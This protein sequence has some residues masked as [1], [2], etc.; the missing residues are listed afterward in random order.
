[1]ARQR[2]RQEQQTETEAGQIVSDMTGVSFIRGLMRVHGVTQHIIRSIRR[3]SSNG[4]TRY[5]AIEWAHPT[6][7]IRRVSCN[8]P[9][10][11]NRRTCKHTKEL[12]EAPGLGL[13]DDATLLPDELVASATP[14]THT[15]ADGRNL[16]GFSF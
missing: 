11:A 16:R 2:Q 4:T 7:D 1:M 10:W 12:I 8:C 13:I 6:T 3:N 15:T 5:T 14:T 9:G